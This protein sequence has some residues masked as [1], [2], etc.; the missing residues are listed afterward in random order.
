[1]RVVII[2]LWI[3]HIAALIGIA[4]GFEDFFLPKSPFTMLYLLFLLIFFF[5]VDTSKKVLLFIGFIITG[6]IVEWVGIGFFSRAN[7]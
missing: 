4:L 1:M 6:I 2:I 5:K 7:L 3:I